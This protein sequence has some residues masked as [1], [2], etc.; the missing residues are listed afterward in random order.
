MINMLN[1]GDEAPNFEALDQNGKIIKLSDFKGKK[2]VMYFYPK[3]DTPGCTIEACEFRDSMENFQEKNVIVLGI[4]VDDIFFHKGFI[5]K[6]NL[7]FILISDAAKKISKD[8]EV[9]NITGKSIRSTFII[10]ENGVIKYIFPK[11]N[12]NGHAKEVLE[13]L[14]RSFN[15]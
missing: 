3:D 7:N 1:V 10:D 14:R 15:L 12:P 11:V 6:H 13:A 4:S 8:Y 9:L 2:V 5:E